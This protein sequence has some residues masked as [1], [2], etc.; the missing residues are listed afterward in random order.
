M[1]ASIG[2]GPRCTKLPRPPSDEMPSSDR[3]RLRLTFGEDAERYDRA[4]PTYPIELFDDL[5]VVACIGDGCRVLELG[6][7]TGQASLPVAS[8]G[9]RLIGL[10]LSPALAAV[11]RERL[12]GF[13]AVEIVTAPFEEW[14]LPDEP[15]DTVLSATA[16]HW[17]DPETRVTKAADALRAGGILA[18]ID[19]Q[20]VAGGT[21]DFFVDVQECYGR[22]D[23]ATP[24]GLRLPHAEEIPHHTD[25]LERSDRFEPATFRRYEWEVGYSTSEY[26]DLLLTYSGHIAL[27]PAARE[28]LLQCIAD[29]IDA[30]YGGRI[31]KRYLAELRMARRG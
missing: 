7:G 12:E 9:C 16:F 20:H 26:L 24:P 23:P 27:D 28:A 22:W 25:E 1:K 31:T 29:L 14:Q 18:T 4:R 13:D 30:R 3:E 2:S 10:E 11:A 19:T 17:L 21:T 15:F 6:V 5:A 8:R